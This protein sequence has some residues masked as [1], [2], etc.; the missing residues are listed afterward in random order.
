MRSGGRRSASPTTSCRTS[1]VVLVLRLADDGRRRV[2][3]AHYVRPVARDLH[4]HLQRLGPAVLA[5]WDPATDEFEHFGWGVT[6]ELARRIGRHAGDFEIEVDRRRE[7]PRSPRRDRRHRAAT[8]PAM[9]S[10]PTGRPPRLTLR[11][12]TLR[13]AVRACHCSGGA[14]RGSHRTRHAPVAPTLAELR[15]SGWRSRTVKAELRSNLLA[16]AG[17]GRAG[18]P[19]HRRLRGFGRPGHR[20]RDPRRPR[21]GLPRRARPGQD[22]DGAAARR[23]ARSVA[24]GRRRRRAQRRPV[25]ADQPGRAGRSSSATA[26]RRRSTG[27]RATGATPRSSRRPTSRSPT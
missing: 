21:P 6:P 2:V 22:P 14:H 10:A 12:A 1:G 26:T 13:L 17:R 24:A 8:P 11:R 16:R 4:G 3:A 25:R 5:T 23:P 15:A 19:G 7:L 20:E 27:S 9:R 18:L